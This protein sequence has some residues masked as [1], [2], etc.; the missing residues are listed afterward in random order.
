MAQICYNDIIFGLKPAV[1]L[2]FSF[3][4]IL[5]EHLAKWHCR[6]VVR[7]AVFI[8]PDQ[9]LRSFIPAAFERNYQGKSWK[10]SQEDF[11]KEKLTNLMQILMTVPVF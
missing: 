6:R 4:R 11:I 8:L 9:F 2:S 3:I 7:E 10:L 1:H 5:I